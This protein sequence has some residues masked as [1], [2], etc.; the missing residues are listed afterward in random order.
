MFVCAFSGV[1]VGYWIRFIVA[2]VVVY[3]GM[4]GVFGVY[5]GGGGGGVVVGVVVVIV[6]AVETYLSE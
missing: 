2:V 1:G 5:C 3:D 6:K 4:R